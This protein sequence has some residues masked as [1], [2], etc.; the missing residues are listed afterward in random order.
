MEENSRKIKI[1]I[2]VFIKR[3]WPILALGA[4][5][6]VFAIGALVWFAVS[7]KGRRNMQANAT[8]TADTIEVTTTTGDLI[9]RSLDGVLVTPDES[10]LQ[11]FAVMV[12]NQIDAR[13]MLGPAKANIVFEMPVEGG[14]TRYLLLFDA[15]ST[16]DAIGP[17]RSARPYYVD[18]ADG[19]NA[20]Y[21]HVG[22]SP[23]AL[24]KI[25]TIS[26]FRNLD[27]FSSG[28][29]FWRSTKRSAPHNT[30]TRMD[31]LQS[32]AAAKKWPTGHFTAWHYKDD[33]QMESTTG[34]VRGDKDGPSLKYGG[35]YNVEW[36]FD[37]Q[38]NIY[39]RYEGG[40][41]QKDQDG[42]VVTAHNVIVLE[43]DGSVLDNVGRLQIRT[44][45]KGSAVLY[46]DG[47]SDKL[48][49]RRTSGENFR[50]ETVDGADAL[51]NR[52]TTWVEVTMNPRVYTMESPTTG[53]TTTSGQTQ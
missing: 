8:S 48:V 45:G 11:P 3:S 24:T 44:T 36:K 5:L 16:V 52:G 32:A 2:E 26:G 13:P 49:W 23:D 50:W 40:S 35:S 37:K 4:V 34:T 47:R 30:Y 25:G 43:T 7:G 1:P 51:L 6:L 12:E 41:I 39:V 42:E 14:I 29:Y 20:V 19:F 53:T 38:K 18:I 10:R 15:T 31:L 21:A 33:S 17:V 22:G 27:E 46:R 9:P 28:K